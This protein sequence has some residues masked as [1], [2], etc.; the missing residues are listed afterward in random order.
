MAESMD[1]GCTAPAGVDLLE[2]QVSVVS[3][4]RIGFCRYFECRVRKYDGA[5]G[6]WD[7]IFSATMSKFCPSMLPFSALLLTY[8]R[9]P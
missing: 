2:D 9:S 3:A 7:A 1:N 8:L 6:A 4:I 5:Y